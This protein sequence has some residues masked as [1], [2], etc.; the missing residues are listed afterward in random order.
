MTN[1][2]AREAS[3]Y[4]K[5]HANNPVDWYPWGEEALQKAVELDRPLLISIGYTACHWCHVMAHE[6]FEDQNTAEVMNSLFINVKI[7]REERPDLDKV[8][9]LSAQLLTRQVG[10]W[11]L[12]VFL[13]PKTQIPFFAGTYFPKFRRGNFPAFRE[14]LEYVDKIYREHKSDLERQNASFRNVLAELESQAKLSADTVKVAPIYEAKRSLEEGYDTINGGFGGAPKFPMTTVLSFLLLYSCTGDQRS[15]EMLMHSLE[16]MFQSGLYDQIGGGFYRYSVDEKWEI[17]HFEKMLYDNSLL[18]AL[19]SQTKAKYG[20][21][22]KYTFLDQAIRGAADWMMLEMQA[23]GGGFYATLAADTEGE[24]GKFYVWTREEIQAVLSVQEYEIATL[25]FNL[26][27]HPNFKKTWHLQAQSTVADLASQLKKSPEELEKQL[28]QIKTKLYKHRSQRVVPERDEK[29]IVSWNG[30]AIKGL[31]LAGFYLGEEKYLQAAAGSVNFIL[32]H[33]YRSGQLYSVYKDEAVHQIGNLDDYGFLIEGIFYLLQAKWNNNHFAFL[34]QLLIDVLE[35]FED[36][37]AG[38]FY[39]TP[40][41][42]EKLIYRLKQ[43]S[44]ESLPSSSAIITKMLLFIGNL[45]GDEAMLFSAE[46]S[47]KNAF[48]HLQQYPDSYC[49]FLITLVL[50]FATPEI[51]IVRSNKNQLAEWQAAYKEHY[52]PN[53]AG[54]FIDEKEKLPP[55]LEFKKPEGEEGVA[56]FCKGSACL[57]PFINRQDMIDELRRDQFSFTTKD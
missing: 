18:L 20:N 31:A 9:Q 23:E 3:P 42:H 56:Y 19:L 33:C 30:L 16:K 46:K 40:N 34:K 45:I 26:D 1:R 11:P 2:L 49:S 7:D 15:K 12:T 17:P 53:R 37:E 24:E 43:Y 54:F 6:S 29:M 51:C 22:K 13:M 28:N 4:L 14:V 36:K 21:E 57:P 52:S 35:R 50:Y 55:P 8:Y 41:D 48:A 32:D 39:F 25:Y 44:D 5:M 47:L 38:G 10:G 27:K